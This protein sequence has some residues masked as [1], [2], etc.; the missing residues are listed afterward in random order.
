MVQHLE[1]RQ[2]L[3]TK[4]VRKT[5]MKEVSMMSMKMLKVSTRWH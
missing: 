5:M 1:H 3:L 4:T 2:G